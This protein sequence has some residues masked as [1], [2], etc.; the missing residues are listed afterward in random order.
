M[1]NV[2]PNAQRSQRA[3]KKKKASGAPRL[4]WKLADFEIGKPLGNGKFGQVYLAREKK[5]KYIVALKVMYKSQLA[6]AGIQHQLRREIEIQSHLRHPNILRMFGYF[7]DATRVYLILEFAAGGELYKQL[8]SV[9]HFDEKR[10]AKYI[11]SLASA[12]DYCHKRNVI[13]RDIK[14]E[15]LLIA[16]NGELKIADFGWSIHAPN[17]RRKTLCGTLDYL[18]PEMVEMKFHNHTADI[19]SLGVLMYEF[20]VGTAPFEGVGEQETFKRIKNVDLHFPKHLSAD[21][22]DLIRKLLVYNPNGRYTLQ[23]VQKH[24]FIVKNK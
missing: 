24:P 6:K 14:P 9:K 17:A 2:Q 11:S 5:T 12:L 1:E 20:L 21:A 7:Y 4:K 10:T 15:N 19:W 3:A 22:Q 18:P 23:N 16:S 8:Q 13:H